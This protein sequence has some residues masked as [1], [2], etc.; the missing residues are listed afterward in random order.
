MPECSRCGDFTDNPKEKE[1]HYCED[2]HE[3]FRSIRESGVVVKRSNNKYEVTVNV[4][5]EEGRSGSEPTQT[6]GLARAK[7]VADD[8]GTKALFEYTK[9]GSMWELENYLNTHPSVRH[10]VLDRLGRVPDKKAESGFLSRL[11]NKLTSIL[12]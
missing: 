12:N 11:R 8:L 1:Y 5:A 6:E 4:E 2:C 9:T 3:F 10:D 7:M